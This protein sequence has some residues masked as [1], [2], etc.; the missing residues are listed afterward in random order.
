MIENDFFALH[1]V[2]MLERKT[3]KKLEGENDLKIPKDK[4]KQVIEF[5]GVDLK[6]LLITL[7][8]RIEKLLDRD[9]LIGHSYFIKVYSWED[10][11]ETFYKNIIPLLQE[12]FFGD[13]AKIGAVLG[14]GF[15]KV[16]NGN[17]SKNKK[18][19]AE[20][21]EFDAGD[22]EERAT[23]E[24]VNYRDKDQKHQIEWNKNTIDMDFEKS[25]KLLMNLPIE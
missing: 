13:Y 1:G 20:F 23:F 19:F 18:L 12:Y 9:H 2:E 17:A 21:D 8:R 11:K 25:I 15:V 5:G 4:F 14:K 3:Y 24:I 16:K 6:D 22:F 7:N 10:L